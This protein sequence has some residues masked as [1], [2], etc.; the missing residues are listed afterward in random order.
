MCPKC[1][2]RLGSF[3]FVSGTKCPCGQYVLPAVHVVNGKI[4]WENQT[5][6]SSLVCS[7]S[8]EVIEKH[9][10]ETLKEHQL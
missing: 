3:D 5:V 7:M 2:G 9:E 6:G 8:D 10:T 1:N 4:D